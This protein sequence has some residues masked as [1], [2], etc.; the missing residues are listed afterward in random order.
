VADGWGWGGRTGD[1]IVTL[2]RAVGGG[3]GDVALAM[4]GIVSGHFAKPRHGYTTDRF[5]TCCTK[6]VI[7]G[8]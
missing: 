6:M 1:V 7:T 4:Y 2:S 3:G 8:T 5:K